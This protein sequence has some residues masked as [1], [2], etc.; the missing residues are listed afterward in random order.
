MQTSAVSALEAHSCFPRTNPAIVLILF[1]QL[2]PGCAVS[3]PQVLLHAVLSSKYVAS[4]E[5]IS[6]AWRA[7]HHGNENESLRLPHP[8]ALVA[9]RHLL[10]TTWSLKLPYKAAWDYRDENILFVRCDWRGFGG[11]RSRMLDDSREPIHKE[12]LMRMLSYYEIRSETLRLGDVL[13]KTNA[14]QL[15]TATH[16]R[17]Q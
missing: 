16:R 4:H 9:A 7:G 11:D 2:A 13:T 12:V 10:N 15:T 17:K 1:P 5:G 3:L 6:R 14:A 8:R